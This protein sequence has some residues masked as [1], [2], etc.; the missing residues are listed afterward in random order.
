MGRQMGMQTAAWAR[1]GT[2]LQKD[3]ERGTT[4]FP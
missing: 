1:T 3:V 2:R 4:E